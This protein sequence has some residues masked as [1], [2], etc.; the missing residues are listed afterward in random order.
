MRD[1]LRLID[2]SGKFKGHFE[3][4][5]KYYMADIDTRT[6]TCSEGLQG[7]GKVNATEMP[8]VIQKYG[9]GYKRII[10]RSNL[11]PR[12]PSIAPLKLIKLCYGRKDM[13]RLNGLYL[14]RYRLQYG[15]LFCSAEYSAVR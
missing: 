4:R 13:H 15:R 14:Y 10:S 11:Q 2:I 8:N 3:Q 5:N 6:C 9:I 7:G 1:F 12:G